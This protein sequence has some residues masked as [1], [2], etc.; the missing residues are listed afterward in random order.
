MPSLDASRHV[1]TTSRSMVS[2]LQIT[3]NWSIEFEP[4]SLAI[5]DHL[6]KCHLAKCECH[7]LGPLEPG[8]QRFDVSSEATGPWSDICDQQDKQHQISKL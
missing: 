3:M 2:R 4:L 6:A 7:G 5:G 1:A 8:F